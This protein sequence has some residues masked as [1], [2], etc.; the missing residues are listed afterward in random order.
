M[1]FSPTSLH[2]FVRFLAHRLLTY[3]LDKYGWE[4]QHSL[5]EIL[6]QKLYE[7]GENISDPDVL[8]EAAKE[9]KVSVCI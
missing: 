6:F 4:K 1:S 8:L 3:T 9:A 7:Q 2:I 5:K